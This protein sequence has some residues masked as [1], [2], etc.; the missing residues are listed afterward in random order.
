MTRE[1]IESILNEI[2]LEPLEE[3]QTETDTPEKK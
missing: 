1:L 3:P 2:G